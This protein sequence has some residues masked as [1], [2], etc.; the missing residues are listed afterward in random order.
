MD[1][2]LATEKTGD[3]G[4]PPRAIIHNKD[5]LAD[6]WGV[7][8]KYSLT[9]RR[10]DGTCQEMTRETYDRG[11]GA[12]VLPYN[13]ERGTIVLTRQ[14]RLPALVTGHE[15]DLIEACAGLLDAASNS[16]ALTA[17]IR[18]APLPSQDHPDLCAEQWADQVPIAPIRCLAP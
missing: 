5:V 14:F 17:R 7:L 11:H 8:T 15:E 3:G 13:L 18:K 10:S 2:V 16:A 12:V 1:A 4:A 9:Y 6:D